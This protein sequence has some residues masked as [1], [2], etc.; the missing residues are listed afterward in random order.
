M[1]PNR[2]R[3]ITGSRTIDRTASALVVA[4][5]LGVLTPQ[6]VPAVTSLMTVTSAR[7]AVESGPAPHAHADERIVSFSGTARN[8]DGELVY[9]ETHTL[10]FE[11]ED[12]AR[13]ETRY[14]DPAGRLIATLDSDYSRSQTLPDYA[15]RDL[16]FGKEEGLRWDGDEVVLYRQKHAGDD[17]E[18]KRFEPRDTHV[19]GQG[20]NNLVV[21]ELDALRR[22]NEV[23]FHFLIPDRL[24]DYRLRVTVDEV[25]AAGEVSHIHLTCELDNWFLRLVAPS[26]EISYEAESG[27]LLAYSG[28]SNL[29]DEDGDAMSVHITYDYNDQLAADGA[30][31][32]DG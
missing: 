5:L 20:F 8:D 27:R 6:A 29:A 30:P 2:E 15:F 23:E 14:F 28:N 1:T 12:I 22:G 4:G 18:K 19:G 21:R 26:L 17:L 32:I 10:W 31:E 24:A 25:E 3:H 11:D 9:T 13:A 16:R 7:I